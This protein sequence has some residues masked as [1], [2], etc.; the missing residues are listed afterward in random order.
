MECI[1]AL[2]LAGFRPA[3]RPDGDGD[4]TILEN[5]LRRVTVPDRGVLESQQLEAILKAAGVPYSEFLDL[6]SRAFSE[7][8]TSPGVTDSGVR[9]P[10]ICRETG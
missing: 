7:H 9:V 1:A 8:D 4:S 6:L 3:S 5:E 2:A 10:I